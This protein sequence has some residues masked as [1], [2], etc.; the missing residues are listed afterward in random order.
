MT[1]SDRSAARQII[2]YQPGGHPHMKRREF[3]TLLGG[4]AAWP[5]AARAEQSPPVIGFL[6]TSSVEAP[7]GPIPAILL[8]LQH[9]GFEVG[10]TVRIEYR[11]ADNRLERLPALAAE[12]VKTPCS[13]IVAAGG[14][15]TATVLKEA[16]STIPIVF[17]PLPDPVRSGLVASLNRPGGNVTGVAALTIELDPKRIELLHELMPP[18]GAI[19]AMY[20]PT[21]PDTQTQL[22]SIQAATKAVGRELVPAP[23]ATV[24]EIDAA[25]ATLKDRAIAGLLIAADP[26]FSS[27]RTQIIDL[28]T[29]YR[30]PAIYQWR[31]FADAGGLA[32]YGANLA[33]S[34]RQVGL[35]VARILRGE[36][37]S[38]LPVQQ[39]TKFEFVINLRTAKSLGLEVPPTLLARAD[40]VIE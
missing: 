31:E 18:T 14:P 13:V 35:F 24:A 23:A 8:A 7:S 34:Y 29:R 1:A 3:I 27:Q 16:T 38:E 36:K 30:W 39:P 40:E 20:N 37:P 19:G 11:Y 2:S 4:M 15:R 6:T 9:T 22:Q 10:Q 32:S 21:R 17:A 28:A 5:L 25:F 33:D 26:F 12:L